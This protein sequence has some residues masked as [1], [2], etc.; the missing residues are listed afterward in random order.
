MYA[1]MF[2]WVIFYDFIEANVSYVNYWDELAT[3][4][5]FCWGAWDFWK[6]PR[7]EKVERNNWIFLILL[8][9]IGALGNVVHPGLQENPVVFIK[10]VMALCKFPV[11]FFLLERRKTSQE[12]QDGRLRIHSGAGWPKRGTRAVRPGSRL[13][14]CTP[15]GSQELCSAAGTR[16][17]SWTC[18]APVTICTS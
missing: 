2:L 12:E 5:V 10:D 9:L 15:Q 16:S 14:V 11:I 17:P 13:L 6:N 18:C 8:V 4:L 1:V 3:C 7:M